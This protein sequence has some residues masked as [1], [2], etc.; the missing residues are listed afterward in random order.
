MSTVQD[1]RK[2]PREV[3][4]RMMGAPAH[5]APLQEN[6]EWQAEAACRNVD[7]ELFYYPDAERGTARRRR[8][9]AAKKVCASCPVLSVCAQFALDNVE[10]YGIWGGLTEKERQRAMN[11]RFR[12]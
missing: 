9:V 6:Y 7:P 3:L 5:T 11:R 1:S 2:L 8:E 4:N 10:V 12:R